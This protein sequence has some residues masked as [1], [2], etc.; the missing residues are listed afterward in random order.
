MITLIITGAPSAAFVPGVLATLGDEP[1]DN[2]LNIIVT[3]PAEAFVTPAALRV[4][5]SGSVTGDRFGE[6]DHQEVARQSHQ[7]LVYPAT[8]DFVNKLAAGITDSL[9][10]MVAQLT[11]ERLRLYVSLPDGLAGNL[12]Y[13][14]SRSVLIDA[15]AVFV[16]GESGLALSS[17][18]TSPGGCPS[19]DKLWNDLKSLSARGES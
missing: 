14:S 1:A 11:L 19:P 3:S 13:R 15:G 9:S 5:S 6:R 4:F 17:R 8:F 7:V 16:E 2:A 18:Q 10:L 12:I